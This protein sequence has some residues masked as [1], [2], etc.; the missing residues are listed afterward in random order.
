MLIRIALASAFAVFSTGALAQNTIGVGGAVV[1]VPGIALPTTPGDLPVFIDTN[2]NMKDGGP[3]PSGGGGNPSSL[4]VGAN[5]ALTAVADA[6]AG[7]DFQGAS[8]LDFESTASNGDLLQVILANQSYTGTQLPQGVQPGVGLVYGNPTTPR[9]GGVFPVNIVNQGIGTGAEDRSIWLD[10]YSFG[11]I[12]DQTALYFWHA[13]GTAAAPTATQ[14]GDR[15]GEIGAFGYS[16]D[17]YTQNESA[18]INFYADQN[19]SNTDAVPVE[20]NT[21]AGATIVFRTSQFNSNGNGPVRGVFDS[22]GN[23]ALGNWSPAGNNF[24]GSGNMI[25]ENTPAAPSTGISN[26]G[27]FF[28][29]AGLPFWFAQGAGGAQPIVIQTNTITPGHHACWNAWG[30]IDDCGS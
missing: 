4:Y 21:A 28:V 16:T 13:G 2:G 24:P 1:D 27:I 5:Q 20:S 30:V 8:R 6:I 22:F 17:G 9:S 15:L 23:F 3:V 19:F 10:L 7:Y 25:I 26:G 11:G 12:N 29:S 14:T 18:S